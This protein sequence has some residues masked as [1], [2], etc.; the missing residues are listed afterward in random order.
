MK[1]TPRKPITR[2]LFLL[3]AGLIALISGVVLLLAG[4]AWPS[5]AV[6]MFGVIMGGIGLAWLVCARFASD[7]PLR[8]V[9]IRYMREFFPAMLL[10]M[11]LI[12]AIVPLLPHVHA[13]W[14]KVVVALVPVLPIAWVI[15]AVVRLIGSSDE[16]ERRMQ[17]EAISIA[18]LTVGM[19]SFAVGLLQAA[20]VHVVH[21]AMILVLPALFAVYGGASWWVRRRYQGE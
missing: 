3:R 12:F 6:M 8:A 15:S 17:L 7:E 21:N 14:L 11:V 16:L 18:S 4:W 9:Y 13:T 19:L 1:Q 10:Y 5:R 2:R 20:G